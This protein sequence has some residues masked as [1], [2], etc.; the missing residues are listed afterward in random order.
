M[1]TPARGHG[2]AG[3]ARRLWTCLGHVSDMSWTCPQSPKAAVAAL[4]VPLHA[5]C[6]LALGD[7]VHLVRVVSD[8][9][10]SGR[11][12]HSRRRT[13]ERHEG[14]SVSGTH[15]LEHGRRGT[16]TRGTHEAVCAFSGKGI[17]TDKR[18]VSGAA[19]G[20]PTHG[21]ASA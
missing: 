18:I 9:S 6:V 10:T 21:P 12:A 5:H 11:N 16:R 17:T 8:S 1:S 14:Q 3:R 19:V 7:G 2:R 13:A 15:V 4:D 20:T